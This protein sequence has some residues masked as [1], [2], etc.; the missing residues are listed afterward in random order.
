M[1]IVKIF[2]KYFWIIALVAFA[3]SKFIPFIFKGNVPVAFDLFLGGYYPWLSDK[4]GFPVGVPVKN[5]ALSDV[6]SQIYPW[7]SLARDQ[8]FSGHF[9]LWNPTSLMGYPFLANFQTGIFYPT[10]FILFLGKL[11]QMRTLQLFIQQL[12]GLFFMFIYL[13]S[14]KI[15]LIG[16]FVGSV[17]Y[18][19]A[20]HITVDFELSLGSRAVIWL[21]LAL[22]LIDRFFK[23]NN[24]WLLLL[25]ALSEYS[26]VTAGQIQVLIFT[27]LIILTVIVFEFRKKFISVL[28][29]LSS[30][31]LGT[32][33]ASPQ[34]IPTAE[35]FFHS[36]RLNDPHMQQLNNGILP[37]K[38]LLTLFVG[39]DIFGNP[40][41]GNYFGFWDYL[42]SVGYLG[43]IS[44]L[45]VYLS[46][47]T[48]GNR[49]LKVGL[50]VSLLFAFTNPIATIPY[51][52]SIPLLNTSAASRVLYPMNFFLTMLAVSGIE[53][54]YTRKYSLKQLLIPVATMLLITTV[55]ISGHLAFARQPFNTLFNT[56]ALKAGTSLRN[57][58]LPLLF[59]FSGVIGIYFATIFPKA[60]KPTLVILS[61]L[62][63]ADLLRFHYKY[64]SY[65]NQNLI[66]PPTPVTQ[67]LQT[68]PGRFITTSSEVLP[69][70]SWTTYHLSSM[71]GY[72]NLA[73]A[74]IAGYFATMNTGTPTTTS[75]ER[76][77]DSVKNYSSPLLD[78][79]GVKYIVTLKRDKIRKIDPNGYLRDDSINPKKFTPVFTDRAVVV[80][81]NT[82]HVSQSYLNYNPITT[83]DDRDTLTKM[84]VNQE[85]MS[86]FTS[87]KLLNSYH[88]KLS[89]EPVS[90]T[91][92][93]AGDFVG[94]FRAKRNAIL[95]IVN[96]NYP[97]WIA[98]IDRKPVK[99]I[100]TNFLFLG[101]E[102]TPGEH[103]LELQFRPVSFYY[104]LI[105][106]AISFI[107]LF[108]IVIYK[109]VIRKPVTV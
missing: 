21:P 72:E 108:M 61:L 64:N 48:K 82:S 1:T 54:L 59:F 57:L 19:T 45:F 28:W 30:L 85:A 37:W 79:A 77:L 89:P 86:L 25:L 63:C 40:S 52:F 13:R 14:R 9:P 44:S 102:V 36:V 16:S 88:D 38:H 53:S 31:L 101:I 75:S 11:P 78:F 17:I 3:I 106:S 32:L 50:I 34:L 27:N 39:P 20:G 74:T 62:I 22:Y 69:S 58:I 5:P 47:L 65:I 2:Q 73:P 71:L 56:D 51:R 104:S 109:E 70:N 10:S 83:K 12:L 84:L 103:S 15:S 18:N 90:L 80:L 26:M 107:T 100:R 93:I 76:Y 6:V 81:E 23:E 46:F 68:H 87:D 55:L 7:I 33:I 24:F 66:F 42:E 49:W 43:I 92:N 41:T 91:Q 96:T 97:G 98:K 94:T 8:V 99:V 60:T 29:I 35:L 105:I 95:N 4:W 67:F